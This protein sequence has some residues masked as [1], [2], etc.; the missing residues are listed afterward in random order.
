[1]M[2]YTVSDTPLLYPSAEPRA[3]DI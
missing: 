2:L 3:S 1:M